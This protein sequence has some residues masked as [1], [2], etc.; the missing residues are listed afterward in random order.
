MRKIL[1]TLTII[2]VGLFIYRNIPGVW[3][4]EAELESIGMHTDHSSKLI[5]VRRENIEKQVFRIDQIYN[6]YGQPKHME[7]I[8]IEAFEIDEIFN[9]FYVRLNALGAVIF[10]DS[11]LIDYDTGELK[12]FRKSTIS[13]NL[14][15]EMKDLF[16]EMKIN[17]GNNVAP[18]FPS[19]VAEQ[20]FETT[21]PVA[22]RLACL[23]ALEIEMLDLHETLILKRRLRL[24]E[25]ARSVF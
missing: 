8:Y 5:E 3:W 20:L 14:V 18:S 7:E 25:Q 23:Q 16:S 15:T 19:Q 22:L 9:D 17:L 24:Y 10:D 12:Y 21:M 6:D 4:S 2:S 13:E 1:L 11:G